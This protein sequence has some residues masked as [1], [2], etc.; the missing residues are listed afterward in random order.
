SLLTIP[1][2]LFAPLFLLA[3]DRLRRALAGAG[4]GMRA[5]AAHRQRPAMAQAAVAAEVHQAL[6]VHRD[7]AAQIALDLIVAVDG[8]A[9]LQHFGVGELV[10]AALQRNADLLDD[11]GRE[12]RADAVDILK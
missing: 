4:V 6:D 7:L 5:L 2:S 1:Y 8:L 9:D 12:L 3:G 10:D 11:L